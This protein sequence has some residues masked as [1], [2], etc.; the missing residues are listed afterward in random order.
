MAIKILY[1]LPYLALFAAPFMHRL[2]K[3]WLRKFERAMAWKRSARRLFSL[4]VFLSLIFIHF[5][6]LSLTQNHY[7]VLASTLPLYLLAS[8]KI[9]EKTVRALQDPKIMFAAMGLAIACLISQFTF[10]FGV[11]LGTMIMASGFYPSRQ[12]LEEFELDKRIT[13]YYG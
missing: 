2:R 6:H 13:K 11:V 4:S 3:G 12:S 1:L 10:T 9:F 7:F 8:H 5:L